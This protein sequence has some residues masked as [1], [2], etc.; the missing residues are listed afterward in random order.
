MAT[1]EELQATYGLFAWFK[2][3]VKLK[4]ELRVGYDDATRL[5]KVWDEANGCWVVVTGVDVLASL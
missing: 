1:L 2:T 3:A 4:G 5:L